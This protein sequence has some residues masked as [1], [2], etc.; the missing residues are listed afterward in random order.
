MGTAGTS[1]KVSELCATFPSFVRRQPTNSGA[2]FEMLIP[3]ETRN[4]QLRM[5]RD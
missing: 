3:S 1:D 4:L 5:G 2:K